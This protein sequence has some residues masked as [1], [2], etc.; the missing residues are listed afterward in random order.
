MIFGIRL[1]PSLLL[2]GLLACGPAIAQDSYTDLRGNVTAEWLGFWRDEKFPNQHDSYLSLAAEPELIHERNRGN[3]IFTFKPFY[4][5]DQHDNK[6]THGDIRELSWI[7]AARDWELNAGIS[8][9]FW[10]V[11]EAVHLVDI[12]NQTDFVENIDGEDKLGQPM[13]NLALIRDWGVVDLFV[14]PYFRERT[15][16]DKE[17]RPRFGIPV[18]NNNVIYENSNEEHHVD[19]AARWS[20]SFGDWDVGIAHFVGTSREPRFV[21]LPENINPVTLLPKSSNQLYEQ[22]HQTSID[23]QATLGSWLWKLEAYTRSGQEDRFT[24]AAGGFEYTF[25]GVHDTAVDVGVISEYLY[26]GRDDEFDTST[27]KL[28]EPF[29]ASVFDN[30][31]VL[32]LRF[33]FN[34]TQ[35]TELLASSIIDIQGDGVSYNVEASRRLTDSWKL[36]MEVRGVFFVDEGTT[37]SSFEND[38]RVRLELTRYF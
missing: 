12:I 18:D 37:L 7:H 16:S 25:V 33:T 36:S 34:D 29:S 38:D 4:R 32:G 8:K 22:I 9:V 31:V 6:R 28:N 14:L 5:I 10:G 11:T 19:L 13:V 3:D 15:F 20:H 24:A 1:H 23:V 30:D 26:D 35:S 17:G 21:F 27:V 2:A